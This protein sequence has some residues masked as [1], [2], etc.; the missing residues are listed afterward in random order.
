MADSICGP[1]CHSRRAVLAGAGVVGVTLLTG[2]ATYGTAADK[3]SG[4]GNGGAP[5][6]GTAGAPSAGGSRRTLARAADIPVGGGTVFGDHGVVVTQP[7]AGQFKAFAAV[8][9]HQGC[10]VASVANGTINCNCHGSAFDATDG[11]V[12]KGPANRPLAPAA[13]VVEHGTIALA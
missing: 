3:P 9:T 7:R 12:R 13:I 1:G 10:T 6:P 8:C 4:G 11:S 2:C 5:A